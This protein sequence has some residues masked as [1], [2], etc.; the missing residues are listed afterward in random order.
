M[1]KEKNPMV[2]AI[3]IWCNNFTHEGIKKYYLDVEEM[4][5]AF[6][7]KM[8]KKLVGYDVD[9]FLEILDEAGVEKVFVPS[10][11]HCSFITKHLHWDIPHDEVA[12]LRDQAPDRIVAIAG[13]NPFSRM[14][15]VRD[16]ER[17]IREL[18]FKGVHVHTYGFGIPINDRMWYPFYAKCAEL[19]VPVIFQV[20]H[21]VNLMPSA[22]GRPVLLD[23]IALYFP[24]L[25]IVGAQ[26]GWPWIEEMIAMAVKHKNVFLGVSGHAPKYWDPSMIRYI[27]SRGKDKVMWGTDYPLL[28]HKEALEQL[29]ELGLR[30]ESRNK[31]LR[32]NVMRVFKL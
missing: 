12:E 25:K 1:R 28:S 13:L 22:M 19:D 18:D 16:L 23:D 5:N 24:E 3:D 31:L 15:G 6:P 17:A 7:G 32:D 30:E 9:K 20:G 2:K 29:E 8:R 11:K 4:V 21:A 26:T 10:A 27:N 14:E